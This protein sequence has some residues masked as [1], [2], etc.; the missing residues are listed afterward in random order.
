[1]L[2]EV[3]LRTPLIPSYDPNSK[4]KIFLK[5]E[6]L[7]IFGSYKIRGVS[8]ALQMASSEQLSQGL[9]AAS[10]GNMAQ[11]VAF[12]AKKLQLPCQIYIPETAP[13]IKKKAIANLGAQLIELP[14]SDIWKMVQRQSIQDFEGLFFHPV[15]TPGLQE[16]YGEIAKEILEDQPEADAIVVPFGVGGLSLGI[17]KTIKK[18]NPKIKV[19]CAEPSTANPLFESMKQGK[20]VQ[21]PRENSFID[22]IGTPEVLPYVF[23]ELR[24]LIEGSLIIQPN[25][26]KEG[27]HSLLTQNKLLVEGAAAVSFAAAQSLVSSGKYHKVVCILSGGNMNLNEVRRDLTAT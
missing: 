2:K 9:S 10:A 8:R 26:A 24:P 4:G 7:Q 12:A 16:G 6:N 18:L 27:I 11:A 15:L 19:F 14:F 5:P 25:T 13:Q 21:V 17:S 23:E 1:M 20:A 3:I 22:A